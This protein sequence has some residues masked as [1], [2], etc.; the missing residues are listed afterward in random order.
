MKS[1]VVIYRLP[2]NLSY[3]EDRE[4]WF[5]DRESGLS[6]KSALLGEEAAE[7]AFH[8]TNAPEEV[9]TDEQ[10]SLLKD[11]NFKGPSLSVGDVV[12]VEPYIKKHSTPAEYYM[13]KSFGWE[14][15][16]GDIIRLLK[17]LPC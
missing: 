12:R 9:L 5:R 13:C 17:H 16:S 8:I 7:E 1:R 14:K 15:Y 2:F 3:S 10:K 11:L 6:Y 4:N